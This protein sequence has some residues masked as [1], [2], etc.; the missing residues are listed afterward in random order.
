MTTSRNGE[1]RKVAVISALALA[2]L[3]DFLV[4]VSGTTSH[5]GLRPVEQAFR[6]SRGLTCCCLGSDALAELR[7]LCDLD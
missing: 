4:A 2:L 5:D 7:N 6:C 1:K 3:D